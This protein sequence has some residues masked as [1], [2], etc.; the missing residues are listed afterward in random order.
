KNVKTSSNEI[1]LL[2]T[3][4]DKG[5]IIVPKLFSFLGEKF[6][7]ECKNYNARLSI[8]YV[9]KFYSL[10]KA[11]NSKIGI[12]FTINGVTGINDWKD[13]KA[14]IRKVA[15]KEDV[16]ILV[17]EINDYKE[18]KENNV[19]FLDLVEKKYRSLMNDISYEQFVSSHEAEGEFLNFSQ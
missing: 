11:T 13:S 7:C 1:D 4:S 16:A 14:F 12:L 2:V 10:L 17:F 19:Q 5:K 8:T 9:G 15:L 18:I 6:L 3:L